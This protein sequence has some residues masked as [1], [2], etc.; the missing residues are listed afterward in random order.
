MRELTHWGRVM[1]I[2]VN[3]LTSIGPY[4]G[5]SPG[6]R[7]PI[8][9]TNAGI[10]LIGPLVTN[11]SEILIEIITFSFKEIRLKVSSAK[12]QPFCPGLNALSDS[13]VYNAVREANHY[14]FPLSHTITAF[15]YGCQLYSVTMTSLIINI[16]Y[17]DTALLINK[18]RFLGILQTWQF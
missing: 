1:H 14:E 12:R 3:R 7:Q 4:N 9:W 5:L 18:D 16:Y 15:N 11:F 13:H 8:I 2:C 17:S 10:L 6:P